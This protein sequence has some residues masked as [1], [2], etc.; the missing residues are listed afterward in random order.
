M[1][2]M[3]GVIKGDSFIMKTFLWSVYTSSPM[4]IRVTIL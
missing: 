2:E 3:T 1:T 4:Y